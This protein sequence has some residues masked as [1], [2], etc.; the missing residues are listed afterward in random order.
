MFNCFM[1]CL[2]MF[3]EHLEK[4][5]F[6]WQLLQTL[7]Y[8][9]HELRL[10]VYEQNLHFIIISCFADCSKSFWF[11]RI[12][13]TLQSFDCE[14]PCWLDLACDLVSSIAWQI[15]TVLPSVK[16]IYLKRCSCNFLSCYDY[17]VINDSFR[18]SNSQWIT[19]LFPV[20]N[21]KN[22]KCL[23]KPIFRLPLIAKKC[24]GDEVGNHWQTFQ[25][26]KK[27]FQNFVPLFVHMLEV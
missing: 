21:L 17:H 12:A 26:C 14:V 23:A 9:G 4:C 22:R 16:F 20:A 5:P 11:L 3:T 2:L 6:L 27:S 7:S 13:S 8:A 25:M 24:V 1:S 19:R 10:W 15:S 18:W